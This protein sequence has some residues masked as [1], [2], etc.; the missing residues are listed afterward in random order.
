MSDLPNDL[1]TD[2]VGWFVRLQNPETSEI[3]WLA[4]R[5]WLEADPANA[6]AYG[7][8]EALWL[9]AD[10]LSTQAASGAAEILK[11]EP[12]HKPKP[13]RQPLWLGAAMAAAAVMAIWVV[14]P[15]L[16]KTEVYQSGPGETRHIILADNSVIDLN[17]GSEMRVRLARSR[18]EV[19]LVTG[20][21]LFDVAH[22][23]KRPFLVAAGDRTIRVVGTQFNVLRD[24]GRLQ[25]TVGRG[26][27]SV[28]K[29]DHDVEARLVAGQQ[30]EHKEGAA[31]VQVRAENASEVFGW[32][33]G[34]LIY[35]N[36]PLGDVARDLTRY[37]RRPVAVEPNAQHIQFTG[38]LRVDSQDAAIH[39]LESFLPIIAVKTPTETS[40]RLRAKN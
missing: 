16:T 37:F 15:L 33:N 26:I 17:R 13:V 6:K 39:T 18:R 14:P 24:M 31:G 36:R 21:A 27:V 10:G 20:E 32:R 9:D 40:L 22:D 28:G 3:L 7:Q 38:S 12:R 29:T 19:T 5:D 8:V 34:L 1:P 4:Y 30:L 23:A 25:I 2:A 35:H 11:F